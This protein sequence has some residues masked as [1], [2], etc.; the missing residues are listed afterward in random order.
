MLAARHRSDILPEAAQSCGARERAWWVQRTPSGDTN[1]W[2]GTARPPAEG[3]LGYLPPCRPAYLGSRTFQ[4]AVGASRAWVVGGMALG[5]GSV[6]LVQAAAA[7]GCLGFYGAAGVPLVQVEVAA[8]TLGGAPRVGINLAHHPDPARDDAVVDICLRAGVARIEA[9]AFLRP[10]L[11]VVRFRFAGRAGQPPRQ[12][13]AKCSR[14]EVAARWLAPPTTALLR[15]AVASGALS[16]EDAAWAARHR[17]ADA[18]IAEGSSGGHTD[19]WPLVALVPAFRALA[20]ASAV[21]SGAPV[22]I[23]AAGG[24]GTPAALVAALALGADFLVGGSVHQ[25]CTESGVSDAVRAALAA[26]SL[27][28]VVQIPAVDRLHTGARV[29]VVRNRFARAALRMERLL[30]RHP[31]LLTAPPEAQRWVED[32]LGCSL[33]AAW[34]AASARL[35]ERDPALLAHALSTPQARSEVVVQ[36]WLARAARQVGQ[37]DADPADVQI[38]CSPAMGAF[39][40]W[41]RQVGLQSPETRTFA[42]VSSALLEGACRLVRAQSLERLLAAVPSEERRGDDDPRG[43]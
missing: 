36:G 26:L 9:S 6:S 39:N 4:Q 40:V 38:W 43:H 24:L 22:W 2:P 7:A 23:G 11:P 20:A 3:L 12:V 16:A 10:T 17:L 13:L 21:P 29:Q 31:D 19:G 8:M 27:A 32:A 25:A 42:A 33:N 15:E 34:E 1:L 28:D 5:I 41:S 14:E 18:L 35:A 37:P 30:L